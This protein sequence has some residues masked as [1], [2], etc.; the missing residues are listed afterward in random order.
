MSSWE[1]E[2]G[3]SCHALVFM[4]GMYPPCARA[5]HFCKNS[6]PAQAWHGHVCVSTAKI[7]VDVLDCVLLDRSH[8]SAGAVLT[9]QS[10]THNI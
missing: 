3:N 1:L 2:E 10:T 5:F 6:T 9:L 7:L 4:T 8:S